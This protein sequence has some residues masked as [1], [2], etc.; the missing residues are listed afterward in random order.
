MLLTM[1]NFEQMSLF[2]AEQATSGGAPS[3]GQLPEADVSF[4]RHFFGAADS[5]RIL[6]TLTEATPWR[7]DH[8]LIAGKSIPLP[9]LTAWYGDPGKNYAYSGIAMYPSPWTETLLDIKAKVEATAGVPFNSVLLNHYRTG[10]DSVAW[11]SDDEPGLGRNPVIASVSFGATRRFH[12]KPKTNSTIDRVAID[13]THGSL[14]LMQG[15]TQHFWLHQVPK[16][17]RAVGPRINLTFR[18]IV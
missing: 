15:P 17:T 14:L 5:D 18:Y 11:H 2:S 16:T 10:Q 3:W 12:L 7:Q 1:D 8:I 6:H 13:L 9:R 4:I